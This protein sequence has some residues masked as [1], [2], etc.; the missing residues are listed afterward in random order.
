[1][2]CVSLVDMRPS[3]SF[4]MCLVC[5]HEVYDNKTDVWSFGVLLAELLT[6][7]IPY[8]HTFMTPVQVRCTAPPPALPAS[9]SSL[10]CWCCLQPHVLMT[11]PG[12]LLLLKVQQLFPT[13]HCA[14]RLVL[15]VT[16]VAQQTRCR[17]CCVAIPFRGPS[18]PVVC[19]PA[20][21]VVCCSSCCHAL[22]ILLA[23]PALC[24]Q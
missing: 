1:M 14:V 11:G 13:G 17:C 5:R 12:W 15:S 3:V 7:L 8:Q 18:L 20:P 21:P 24:L 9:V 16:A 6:G 19:C 2:P 10:P 4:C 22:L 23:L